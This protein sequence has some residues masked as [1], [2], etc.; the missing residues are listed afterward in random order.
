MVICRP[1]F[2]TLLASLRSA[3][4][5]AGAPQLSACDPEGSRASAEAYFKAHGFDVGSLSLEE[6]ALG[7]AVY[8]EAG[9]GTSEEKVAIAE[10]TINHYLFYKKSH[11]WKSL[12][13]MLLSGGC[14][15]GQDG[16]SPPMSTARNPYWEDIMAAR[17]ALSG[18]SDNFVRGAIHYFSGGLST[19]NSSGTPIYDSWSKSNHWVGDLPGVRP[20]EQ[21]FMAPGKASQAVFD[22]GRATLQNNFY[23]DALSLRE[24]SRLPGLVAMLGGVAV[25][26]F[27][28]VQGRKVT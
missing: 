5:A 25:A 16:E 14:F 23:V 7:R 3:S 6:Y 21:L 19:E 15:R 8:S 26:G 22:A 2:S 24:C 20:H 9:S 11:G 13:G 10:A 1:W 4:H 27:A 18:A 12:I 17:L 28:V